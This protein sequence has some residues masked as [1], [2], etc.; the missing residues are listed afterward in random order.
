M[1]KEYF[2]IA[3]DAQTP[4]IKFS[5]T[6]IAAVIK[7]NLMAC[8]TYSSS[9]EIKYASIPFLKASIKTVNNGII[10]I[11]PKNKTAVP[12]KRYFTKGDSP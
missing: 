9:K 12:I 7:V 10:N 6:A 1:I 2:A 8:K 5:G 3:Q 11:K 4:K